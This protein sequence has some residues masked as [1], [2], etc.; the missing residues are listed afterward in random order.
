MG[1]AYHFENSFW[2]RQKCACFSDIAPGAKFEGLLILKVFIKDRYTL[3]F[4]ML[5]FKMVN[6]RPDLIFHQP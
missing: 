5:L 1:K 2:P 6:H 3:H 4:D